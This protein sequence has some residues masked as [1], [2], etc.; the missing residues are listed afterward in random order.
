[1]ERVWETMEK[2]LAMGMKKMCV[3]VVGTA[4]N[5]TCFGFI[6]QPQSPKNLKEVK[7]SKL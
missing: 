1:M 3:R 2:A 6:G 4:S 5:T 7:L